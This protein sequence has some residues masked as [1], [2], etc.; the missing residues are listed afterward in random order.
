MDNGFDEL[1]PVRYWLQG[2]S[3]WREAE[4]WPVPTTERRRYYLAAV[5]ENPL[6]PQLIQTSPV[7]VEQQTSFLAIPQGMPY[8]KEIE[9]HEA[10]V[11]R[12]R[13][14]PFPEPIEVVG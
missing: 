4:D 10:Q 2:A 9:H 11:L 7:G 13:T 6:E 5:S 8:L 12:Y 14:E 1:P 3:R